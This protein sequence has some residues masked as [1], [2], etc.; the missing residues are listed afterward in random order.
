MSVKDYGH[1][2]F[3]NLN[4]RLQI[5]DWRLLHSQFALPN[6]SCTFS[7][8]VWAPQDTPCHIA[9]LRPKHPGTG[10][11]DVL[12]MVDKLYFV[13]RGGQLES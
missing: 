9:A 8:I 10:G 2:G 7:T 6:A 11:K 1:L 5:I 3:L 4:G 12:K 13:N